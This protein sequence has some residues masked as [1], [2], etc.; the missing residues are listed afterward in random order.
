VNH[1]LWDKTLFF[2][3]KD[4]DPTENS[5]TSTL[6]S[7]TFKLDKVSFRKLQR[8]AFYCSYVYVLWAPSTIAPFLVNNQI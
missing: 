2:V 3:K 1:S 5:P 8:L 7:F 4:E 6:L